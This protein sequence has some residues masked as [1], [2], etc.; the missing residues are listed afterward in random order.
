MIVSCQKQDEAGI[1][2]YIGTDYPKCLYLY[3]DLLKYGTQSEH[4]DV[5]RIEEAGRIRAVLLRYYSC[6]HVYSKENDFDGAQIGTLLRRDRLTMVYCAAETAKRIQD[7]LPEQIQRHVSVTKGWVAR[8][9][10]VDR[11]PRGLAVPAREEDFPQ[12]ARLIYEDADIGRSYRYEELA[13]QLLERNRE[14][15]ARNLVIRGA[16]RIMA[17]ACT[18]AEQDGIAVVAELLV[19]AEYRRQGLASEIWRTLCAQLLQEGKEVFSFYYSEESRALHR[20]IGFDEVCAWS[21][22]V[23]T[24]E[25]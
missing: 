20:K 21:K 25:T 10:R 17:H 5:Y 12:I 19:R 8:I 16:D 2:A 24:E 14:G 1:L 3:L 22:L 11:A 23:I 13:G 18:N 7:S 4:T 9:R 6:L 15:Y